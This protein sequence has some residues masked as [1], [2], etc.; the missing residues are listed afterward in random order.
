MKPSRL[1][2]FALAGALLFGATACGT[3]GSYWGVDQSYPV[4]S[5]HV[6]YGAHGHSGPR[7]APPLK[8]S[9]KKHKH[10]KAP[11][12]YKPKHKHPRDRDWDDD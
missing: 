6:Y 2:P 9:Y 10:K 7:H 11:K 8:R 12:W 3:M 4:G 1:L 5:G